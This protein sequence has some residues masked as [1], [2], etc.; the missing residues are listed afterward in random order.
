MTIRL[1][2]A[3]LLGVLATAAQAQQGTRKVALVIAN[4]NYSNAGRL[5]NPRGD[6]T[7][8]AAPPGVRGLRV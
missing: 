8:V 2:L 3:C 4:G 1:L 7:L 5:S 6:G